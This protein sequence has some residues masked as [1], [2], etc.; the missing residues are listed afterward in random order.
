MQYFCELHGRRTLGA[1]PACKLCRP[2]K[3]SRLLR[4]ALRQQAGPL[5]AL[6]K[7]HM[8]TVKRR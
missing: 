7:R 4:N 2:V 5:R 6:L 8:P 1:A 3:R